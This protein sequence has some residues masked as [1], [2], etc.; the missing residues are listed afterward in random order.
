VQVKNKETKYKTQRK[1]QKLVSR[2]VIQSF[3]F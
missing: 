3:L 2:P 1:I